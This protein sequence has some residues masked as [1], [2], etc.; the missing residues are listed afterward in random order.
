M[1]LKEWPIGQKFI[2]KSPFGKPIV[3][4]FVKKAYFVERGKIAYE[5]LKYYSNEFVISSNGVRYNISEIEFVKTYKQLE[6]E[7]KINKI[8]N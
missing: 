3:E 2:Y 4:C 6:R 1:N 7:E 5:N 8:L